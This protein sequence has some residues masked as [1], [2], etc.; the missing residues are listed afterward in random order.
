[1]NLK[2]LFTFSALSKR[3]LLPTVVLT[4]ILLFGLGT[5]IVAKNHA[6]MRALM[7]SKGNAMADLLGKISA[8][9]IMNYDL[10]A[11]E[12]F[13]RDSLKDPEVAFVVFYDADKKP[14][15]EI[16]KAPEKTSSFL[17]YEREISALHDNGRPIGYLKMGYT[18][19][20][21]S[22]TLQSG[23][24]TVVIGTLI[25]ICSLILG[26][27]ILFRGITLPL[28]DLAGIV[29]QVAQG[30]LTVQVKSDTDRQDEISI[31]A[32][33]FG[34]MSASLKGIIHRI[35]GTSHQ[36]TQVSEQV[37]QGA[38]KV[39]K[40]AAQQ[41]GAAAKTSASVDALNASINKIAESVGSLSASAGETSS[42][43]TEMSVAV[44]QVAENTSALSTSVEDTASSLLEMSSSI[45][46]VVENIDTLSSCAGEATSSIT[47]MNAS[48][49]E[50]ER[51]AKDSAVLSDKVNQE[52]AELGIVAIEQSI[53]GMEQIKKSVEKS[54]QVI[55]KLEERTEQIG[56]ILTVIDEVTRQTNLLA[57]N[58]SILA[59]QAGSE[60]KGFAV[61][62]QEIKELA[63]RTASSTKEIAQ[64]IADVQLET[65]NA[66]L[67]AQ[68]GTQSVEEGVRRSSQA[69]GSLNKILE[70]SKRS[71]EMSRQI[72]RATIE[73][74]KASNQVAQIMQKVN[75]MV[76]QIE[77]AMKELEMGTLNITRSSEKM[78]SITQQVKIATEEQARGSKQISAA[79]GNI[80]LRIQQ[81]AGTIDEQKTGSEV[82]RKAILEIQE[83]A[84]ISSQM[85]H[86]VNQAMETLIRQTASLHEEVN[87]FKI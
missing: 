4:V 2:D 85:V 44:T 79:G 45:K 72:E 16:S 41:A 48:I 30:D 55:H 76:H 65:K 21:L 17:V 83:I 81:I 62:A 40:G 51:N 9:Y 70:S 69:R 22:R 54:S 66:V 19:E 56:E 7:E 33:A 35:Q 77:S 38:E 58:A 78:R 43:L 59:A 75:D 28:V 12:G 37:S 57:L 25:A 82:I 60:G 27:I 5:I 6:T 31:L 84:E 18:G 15:T 74:V 86:Q 50:V 34:K 67:S 42:S 46:Q 20:T 49:K 1:M 10:S 8:N 13:V 29:D 87:R 80:T 23:L 14:L 24:V 63:D 53:E 71:L 26:V 36:I 52:A 73:Q 32:N 61:V 68:E 64:L 3:F 39:K 11:L 47:Q